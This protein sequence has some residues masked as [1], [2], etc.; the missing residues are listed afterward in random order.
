MTGASWA[1]R[2]VSQDRPARDRL[3]ARPW[4]VRGRC[5]AEGWADRERV[6]RPPAGDVGVAGQVAWGRARRNGGA[7][8]PGRSEGRLGARKAPVTPSPGIPAEGLDRANAGDGGSP[9]GQGDV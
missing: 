1:P 7:G 8:D 3:L 4:L 2:V 6:E 5:H 9:Q